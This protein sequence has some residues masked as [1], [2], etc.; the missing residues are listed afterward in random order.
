MGQGSYL[1]SEKDFQDFSRTSPG[2]RVIF[3]ELKIHINPFTPKISMLIL[4]TV[5][6]T[7]HIFFL[8]ELNRLPNLSRTISLFQGFFSPGKYHNKI[9]DFPGFP[10]PVRTLGTHKAYRYS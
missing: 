1:F 7:H 8:L 10:G 2:L 5:C 4:L 6:H 9:Q 3:P